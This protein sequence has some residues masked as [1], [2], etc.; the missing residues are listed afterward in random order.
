MHV[1]I[2]VD[3]PAGTGFSYASTDSYLHE[4][5]EVHTRVTSQA[6]KLILAIDGWSCYRIL[7][8]LL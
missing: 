4:L 8:K 6:L 1:S 5:D 7:T 3:Q 2:P